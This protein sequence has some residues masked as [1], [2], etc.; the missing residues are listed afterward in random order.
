MQFV[1]R[2]YGLCGIYGRFDSKSNR[3]A[4]SI[5]YSIRTQKTIRRSLANRAPRG[6]VSEVGAVAPDF[7]LIFSRQ[8][9]ISGF[10]P[11]F[12][13]QVRIGPYILAQG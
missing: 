3:T 5:R 12:F 1:R 4:D 10:Y 7:R 6:R 11:D 8:M 13:V 2:C 9:W